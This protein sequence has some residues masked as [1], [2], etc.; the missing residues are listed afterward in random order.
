LSDIRPTDTAVIN[1]ALSVLRHYQSVPRTI[2][3]I[4]EM[5]TRHYTDPK[6]RQGNVSEAMKHLVRDGK[7]AR[8]PNPNKKENYRYLY[9]ALDTAD[10]QRPKRAS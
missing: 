2:G 1:A 10:W 6:V 4:T 5:I 9:A 8:T 3:D 7:A